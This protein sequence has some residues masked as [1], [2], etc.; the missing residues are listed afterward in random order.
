MAFPLQGYR[1][2]A[3]GSRM[4]AEGMRRGTPDVLLA[5]A[6]GD[7]HSLWIEMKS[8]Q[9]RLS[10]SQKAMLKSLAQQ[11]HATVVCRSTALAILAIEGYL[12][13]SP[14]STP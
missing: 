4:K 1:T 11:G 8:D 6:R 2:P 7:Y 12:G 3:N 5:I 13:H 9:G 14:F 10:L